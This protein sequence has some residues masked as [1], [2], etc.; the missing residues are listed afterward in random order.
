MSNKLHMTN[1]WNHF[2]LWNYQLIQQCANST[3]L[4][5]RLKDQNLKVSNIDEDV[6]GEFLFTGD[7]NAK[8]YNHFEITLEV[9]YTDKYNPIIWSI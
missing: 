3:N 4:Q 9:S 2:S 8:Q 5:K 1:L 7:E 6:P